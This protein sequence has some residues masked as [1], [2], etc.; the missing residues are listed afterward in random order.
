MAK[1][2]K[3]SDKLGSE[4]LDLLA[5]FSSL[6][7]KDPD[8]LDMNARLDKASKKLFNKLMGFPKGTE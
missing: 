3:I 4:L 7:W 2:I 1:K 6:I 8:E 5:E